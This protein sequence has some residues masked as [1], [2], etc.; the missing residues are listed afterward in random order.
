MNNKTL[1]EWT[2]LDGEGKSLLTVTL[3]ADLT[4]GCE[5]GEE[6]CRHIQLIQKHYDKFH[7]RSS[8]FIN[9]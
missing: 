1:E 7:K 5:C 9:I 2:V 4:Y 8:I 3:Y 6:N